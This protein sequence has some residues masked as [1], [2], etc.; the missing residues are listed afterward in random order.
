M[1]DGGSEVIESAEESEADADPESG[2]VG[3]GRPG[4]VSGHGVGR[5]EFSN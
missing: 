2:D 1:Y 4:E 3:E 5:S